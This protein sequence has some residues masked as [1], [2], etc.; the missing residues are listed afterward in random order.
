MSA[1]LGSGQCMEASLE[2]LWVYHGGHK[3]VTLAFQKE[4]FLAH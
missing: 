4:I 2:V 3:N 1:R